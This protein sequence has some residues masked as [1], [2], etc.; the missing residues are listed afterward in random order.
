M[1]LRVPERNAKAERRCAVLDQARFEFQGHDGRAIAHT[2]LP[3][4]PA[5]DLEG[6][7]EGEVRDRARLVPLVEDAVHLDVLAVAVRDRHQ[8]AVQEQSGGLIRQR[9][10]RHL[11]RLEAGI[12]ANLRVNGDAQRAS[13]LLLGLSRLLLALNGKLIHCTHDASFG[14]ASTLGLTT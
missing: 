4:G 7:A 13:K 2:H 6:P 12:H 14:Y 1:V 10:G 8:V 9:Q 3:I 11:T 5:V